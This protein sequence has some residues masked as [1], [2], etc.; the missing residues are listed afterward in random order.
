MLNPSRMNGL[1]CSMME[2]LVETRNKLHR[3]SVSPSTVFHST[4]H[5]DLKSRILTAMLEYNRKT[6]EESLKNLA[7][8]E[9]S[10]VMQ[11][12]WLMFKEQREEIII[13]PMSSS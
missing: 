9:A 13:H 1:A 10:S 12:V 6:I 4:D 8:D 7:P 5:D 11:D 3:H 2:K